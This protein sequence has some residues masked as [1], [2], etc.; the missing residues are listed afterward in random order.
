[1]RKST[2]YYNGK[3]LDLQSAMREKLLQYS[4]IMPNGCI[5]W[6]RHCNTT[7]GRP[8]TCYL[9]KGCY[10]DEVFYSLTKGSVPESMTLERTC[11][12]QRCINPEH[13][14]LVTKQPRGRPKTTPP[15][16][17]IDEE[18]LIAAI[19]AFVSDRLHRGH[20]RGDRVT[21][22]SI[23]SAYI[24]YL[25]TRPD[26]FYHCNLV[27]KNKFGRLFNSICNPEVIRIQGRTYDRVYF[28]DKDLKDEQD[29]K[30]VR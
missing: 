22:S 21:R 29:Q 19:T 5:V 24:Y 18:T 25:S 26:E 4:T 3:G 23:F 28:I 20:L 16:P 27:T 8:Y 7:N 30:T 11:A 17:Y 9:G 13:A 1:M 2:Q 6:M 10:A 15:Q 12:E 14:R